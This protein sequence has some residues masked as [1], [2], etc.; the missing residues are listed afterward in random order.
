MLRPRGDPF[1]PL[2]NNSDTHK[3]LSWM[4]ERRMPYS[5]KSLLH[6]FLEKLS[7]TFTCFSLYYGD[8][9]DGYNMQDGFY[10]RSHYSDDNWNPDF[11][12]CSSDDCG[13]CQLRL[14][15]FPPRYFFDSFNNKKKNCSLC[16]SMT[17]SLHPIYAVTSRDFF[18]SLFL[19]SRSPLHSVID[20]ELTCGQSQI[21]RV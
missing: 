2:P 17:R 7:R 1:Y 18:G 14:L 9:Y 5:S 3:V 4:H 11:T 21:G 19:Q 8:G 16:L 6:P 12:A 10:N 13:M 15:V 20:S